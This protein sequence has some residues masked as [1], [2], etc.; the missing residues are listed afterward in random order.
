MPRPTGLVVKNGSKIRGRSAAAMPSPS[1]SATSATYG[2][3]GSASCRSGVRASTIAG[4]TAS[5]K[6]PP[7]R[8]ASRALAAR[9]S[10]TCE[11]WPGSARTHSGR[12]PGSTW[13]DTPS[14]SRR[15]NMSAMSASVAARSMVCGRSTCLRLK[16][17]SWPTRSAAR[18]PAL[19]ISAALDCWSGSSPRS[20]SS[21]SEWPMIA[22]RRLL[23]SCA[24]PLESRPS[25]SILCAC[26]SSASSRRRSVRSRQTT[27]S[28][29]RS[30]IGTAVSSTSTGNTSPSARRWSHSKRWLP[31]AKARAIISLAFS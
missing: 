14:P 1:S 16:A 21:S 22:T 18:R 28:I 11:T 26:T 17:R 13:V 23:K 7:G 6:R 31:C 27:C 15:R 9:F 29:E 19:R 2:P 20:A 10:A 5:R 24:M 12:S 25:A 4:S 30:G 3:G 8:T